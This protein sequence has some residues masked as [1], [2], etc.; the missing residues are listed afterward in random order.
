V[1]ILFSKFVLRPDVSKMKSFNNE[2]IKATDPLPP[3]TKQ[4]KMVSVG[5]IL[6]IACL[7]FPSILRNV[8]FLAVMRDYLRIVPLTMVAILSV[9]RTEKKPVIKVPELLA[10]GFAWPMVFMVAT[11]LLLASALTNEAT[12]VTKFLNYA[13]SPIFSGMSVTVFTIML[14]IVGYILT[15]FCNSF[16][17]SI[18]LSPIV[19]T[20]CSA[21]GAS[22]IPIMM[23]LFY[24]VLGSALCT[25]SAS[26]FGALLHG[27]ERLTSKDKLGYTV[28]LT[29]V[30]LL[31]VIAVG[32]PLA[33]LLS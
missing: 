18:V 23:L 26:P 6:V 15:N 5:M 24:V 16:V 19:A 21:T 13:L 32:I 11:A 4:Q 9:I 2:T 31:V 27:N 10:K 14:L 30:E 8:P 28:S 20:Y 22:P 25:P 1:F 29:L 33:N 12:G 7:L 3:M 17:I